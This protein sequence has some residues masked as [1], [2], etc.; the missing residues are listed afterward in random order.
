MPRV[1]VK[2]QQNGPNLVFV[3]G[4]VST[5]LCRCGHSAGKP[6]CDGTHAKVEFKAP[7]HETVILE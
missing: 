5:A 7:A 4:K 6:Y 3:D 2:S 1:V